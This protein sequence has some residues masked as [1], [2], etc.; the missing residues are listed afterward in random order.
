[1]GDRPGKGQQDAKQ[2]N[3]L[4]VGN[5]KTRSTVKG[6]DADA[7]GSNKGNKLQTPDYY[8]RKKM[9]LAGKIKQMGRLRAVTE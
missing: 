4:R 2:E 6:A 8:L 5:M 3:S 9:M 7:G 1:M